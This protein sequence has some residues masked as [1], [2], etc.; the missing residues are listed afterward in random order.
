VG[1]AATAAADARRGMR[2]GART[3]RTVA[4]GVDRTARRFAADHPTL[5]G[6]ARRG[7]A[8]VRGRLAEA[9]RTGDSVLAAGR[10]DA[11]RYVDGRVADLL[12][13][14]RRTVVP[15]LLDSAVPQLVDDVVPR[16]LSG[17]LPEIRQ[18]LIPVIVDDLAGE[19]AV[20]DLVREQSRGVIAAAAEQVR[21]ATGTADDRIESGLRRLFGGQR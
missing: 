9:R 14:T 1:L 18:R 10:A 5:T 7:A 19:P 11:G 17:V 4:D 15:P 2:A 21:A 20:R 13:W 12:G 6:P 3:A 16:I 8:A